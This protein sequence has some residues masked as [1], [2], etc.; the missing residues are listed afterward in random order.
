MEPGKRKGVSIR[1]FI[2]CLV[3]T[4]IIGMGS[5]YVLFHTS[6]S[7]ENTQDSTIET[8]IETINNN[9]LDTTESETSITDRMIQGIVNGLGDTHTSY[10]TSEE[11]EDFNNSID[12]DYVGIGVE[13]YKVEEGALITRVF[14]GSPASSAGLVAGEI[15]TQA[16]GV[17]L[18][19]KSSSKIKSLITGEENTNVSI[20]VKN[21]SKYENLKI[22]RK[23]LDTDV[24]YEVRTHNNRKYGYLEI[25]TVGTETTKEVKKA[26]KT[27]KSQNCTTLIMDL[28]GNGGGYVD[29]A[30]N[31]LDLFN[32]KGTTQFSIKNKAGKETKYVDSTEQT[33]DFDAGY[34]LVDGNTASAAELIASNLSEV[35]GYQLVG[36]KTYGKGTAQTQLS[37]PN[38]GVLKYTYAAWYTSK[39]K[40]I[41]KK[42]LTPDVKIN[43]VDWTS[44]DISTFSKTYQYDDVDTHIESMEIMLKA[45]GYKPGRTDGYFSKQVETALKNF[46]KDQNITVNGKYNKEVQEYLVGAYSMYL[47]DDTNDPQYQKVL[48]LME[49]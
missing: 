4:L 20:K 22:T 14:K 18:K 28:R 1:A 2:V 13:F 12:G 46:Q 48:T 29:T 17:S 40:S 26:L 44:L 7:N 27:F 30:K 33:F 16:N 32:E 5:G 6:S 42:G 31:I 9:W 35:K 10:M 23:S 36:T 19:G 8:I 38:G 49:G 41:N 34:I 45:L 37:L 47:S 15:I 39:G 24:F 25:T 43:K 21:G 3:I 11:T